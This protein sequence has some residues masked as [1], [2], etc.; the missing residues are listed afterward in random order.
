M[1]LA[2]TARYSDVTEY[3]MRKTKLNKVRKT[4]RAGLIRKLD[5]AVSA[6]TLAREASCVTCGSTE[7]GTNGHL[8][9]RTAYSTRFD[10]TEDGNCHRQCW[11]CN[12]RHEFDPYP[13]MSW[14][15]M[16]FGKKKLE[17]LHRRYRTPVKLKDSDLKNMIEAIQI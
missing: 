12:Y 3:D 10:I 4:S 1:Y 17:E 13:Y 5:K 7:K 11:P 15:E 9:S 2:K 6:F 8:F 14:Y 16:E